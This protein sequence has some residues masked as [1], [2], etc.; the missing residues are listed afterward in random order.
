MLLILMAVTLGS[1]GEKTREYEATA[2]RVRNNSATMYAHK[3]YYVTLVSGPVGK[4]GIPEAIKLDDRITV[5]GR[6]LT[7]KY[8]FVKEILEDMQWAGKFLARKGD[9]TCTIVERFQ[10]LP[11]VDETQWRN[12]LW[13]HVTECEPLRF[14]HEKVDH[15]SE[16]GPRE[17]RSLRLMTP[18][19]WAGLSGQEE[20]IYTIGALETW[21]FFLY[22]FSSSEAAGEISDFITCVRS[23]KPER[24]TTGLWLFGDVEKKSAAE[25]IFEMTKLVCRDYAGKGDK[26]GKP[27]RVLSK[28]AW[29][30][31]DADR[32]EI[33]VIAYLEMG[34]HLEKLWSSSVSGPTGRQKGAETHKIL[35]KCLAGIGIDGMLSQVRIDEKAFEW[36]YP[37]PWS[38]SKSVGGLCKS[39][40]Q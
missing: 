13:I 1:A 31:L 38:I 26:S 8:I 16:S 10:D 9:V 14:P 18:Y 11:H 27:L 34:H 36:E 28:S 40:V 35:E 29:L 2:V 39:Y 24:F 7:V 37:L 23:E 3:N 17:S 4:E 33:Y 32:K 21:S 12:R 22:S 30:S 19:K 25:H 5:K 20:G 6:S 15:T